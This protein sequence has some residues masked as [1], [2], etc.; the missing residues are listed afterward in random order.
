[1]EATHGILVHEFQNL[2]GC[3]DEAHDKII[4]LQSRPQTLAIP[5]QLIQDISSIF[6]EILHGRP[7]SSVYAVYLKELYLRW[8]LQQI[9]VGCP[10]Y[11]VT[12]QQFLQ[13]YSVTQCE[14]RYLLC[15]F[16]IHGFCVP[17]ERGFF[18]NLYVG[19]VQLRAFVSALF[20]QI[21]WRKELAQ[22]HQCQT[23]TP[24]PM[25]IEAYYP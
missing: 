16:F 24:F 7:P 2:K 10:Y 22:F 9:K 14:T 11:L 12:P 15:E 1:M 4:E 23:S 17:H 13:E 8:Q 5:Q 3:H 19:E 6:E 25:R 20:N 18:V 21:Q